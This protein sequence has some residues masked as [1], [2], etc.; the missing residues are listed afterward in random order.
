MG[1]RHAWDLEWQRGGVTRH[2]CTHCG[3]KR[4]TYRRAGDEFPTAEYLVSGTGWTRE[5]P[6]CFDAGIVQ[7]RLFPGAS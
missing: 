4:R 3:I 7:T 2:T 5:R 1:L 6:E